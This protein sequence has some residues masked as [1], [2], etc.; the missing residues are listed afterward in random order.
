MLIL[1]L[2]NLE[3]QLQNVSLSEG[4]NLS[5]TTA[6]PVNIGESEIRELNNYENCNVEQNVSQNINFIRQNVQQ[7]VHNIQHNVQHNVNVQQHNVNV[8]QHNVNI[9][10]TPTNNSELQLGFY[11]FLKFINYVIKIQIK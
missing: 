4:R 5:L 11:F 9:L 8:Q 7:N 6:G 2:R 3:Q 1:F 10:P